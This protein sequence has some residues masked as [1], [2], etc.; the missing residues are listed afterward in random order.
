MR[1][2]RLTYTKKSLLYT[3]LVVP[4][5]GKCVKDVRTGL[6]NGGLRI[7]DEKKKNICIIDKTDFPRHLT[8]YLLRRRG[9]G[10]I[11]WEKNSSRDHFPTDKVHHFFLFYPHWQLRVISFRAHISREMRL[12]IYFNE[13]YLLF[14]WKISCCTWK[15]WGQCLSRTVIFHFFSF[16]FVF[17][18]MCRRRYFA[19]GN[20]KHDS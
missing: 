6:Q 17:C 13:K 15:M 19:G 9:G 11:E 2:Y 16:F 10:H 20:G 14:S 12:H 3:S 7:A 18:I 4:H 5:L 8:I 1:R